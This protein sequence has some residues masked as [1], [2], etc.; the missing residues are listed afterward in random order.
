MLV[1][2]GVVETNVAFAPAWA[3]RSLFLMT[4]SSGVKVITPWN[5]VLSLILAAKVVVP[6]QFLAIPRIV[7]A[8]L[9]AALI[10]PSVMTRFNVSG[11]PVLTVI[12]LKTAVFVLMQPLNT[13]C[14]EASLGL[15]VNVRLARRILVLPQDQLTA[16]L[17]MIGPVMTLCVPKKFLAGLILVENV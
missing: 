13:S 7:V 2:L 10:T 17:I 11:Q 14:D 15:W 4:N 6:K 3:K 16:G 9:L 5:A 1:I 8:A 12:L